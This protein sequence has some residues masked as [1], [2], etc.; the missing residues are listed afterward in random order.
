LERELALSATLRQ[1]MDRITRR[2][3]DTRVQLSEDYNI[4]IYGMGGINDMTLFI[5]QRAL[6]LLAASLWVS[7]PGVAGDAV[8][9]A[10]QSHPTD[11]L[12][13][14][15]TLPKNIAIELAAFWQTTVVNDE[16]AT[17]IPVSHYLP[18]HQY[19]PKQAIIPVTLQA[20]VDDRATWVTWRDLLKPGECGWQL[21][22]IEYKAD[23]SMAGLSGLPKT[24]PWSRISFVCLRDCV[25]N[26]PQTNDDASEPV[27]QYC[28]FSLL[29]NKDGMWNPC[30]FESNGKMWLGGWNPWKIST[31]IE[32]QAA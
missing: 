11:K 25:P 15:G 3:A 2:E 13:V 26:S 17:K 12:T 7:L 22:S 31:H 18:E 14:V 29:R 5:W 19:M 24:S 1:P 28:K 6:L 9:Y 21:S 10:I 23:T 8:P 16:C 4:R 20:R 32:N 27:H 30:I